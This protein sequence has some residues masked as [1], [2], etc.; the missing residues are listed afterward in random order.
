MKRRSEEACSIYAANVRVR[1]QIASP[2]RPDRSRGLDTIFDFNPMTPPFVSTAPS[3]VACLYSL[4]KTGEEKYRLGSTPL[5]A[6][7]QGTPTLLLTL[8]LVEHI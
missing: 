3:K 8:D 1:Q 5:P 4:Q 7:S 6:L 2:T